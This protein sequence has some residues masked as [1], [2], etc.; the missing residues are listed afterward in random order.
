[1]NADAKLDTLLGWQAGVALDHAGL[2]FDGAAHGV[3]HAAK[4]DDRTVAGEFD[5]AAPMQRDGRIDEIA[6]Q[7]AQPRERAL[8][9][10]A[11]EPAIAD[12]IRNQDRRELSGVA[13]FAPLRRRRLAQIADGV[14]FD[15]RLRHSSANNVRY[16]FHSE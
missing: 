2:H 1:M 16:R 7:S 14:P 8:L 10:G 11:G 4:L 12:D 5:D 3:D 6:A 9:I 13:Q 15:A